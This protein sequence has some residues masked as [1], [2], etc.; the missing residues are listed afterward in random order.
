MLDIE[1]FKA[2]YNCQICR[3]VKDPCVSGFDCSGDFFVLGAVRVDEKLASCICL[4]PLLGEFFTT[5]VIEDGNDEPLSSILSIVPQPNNS[6]DMF[7]KWFGAVV[8]V[9]ANPQLRY[10]PELSGRRMVVFSVSC[11]DGF[12]H[13]GLHD[14][15]GTGGYVKVK[16][17]EAAIMDACFEIIGCVA[18]DP[19]NSAEQ[20]LEK[21]R[22]VATQINGWNRVTSLRGPEVMLM[23]DAFCGRR[24]TLAEVSERELYTFPEKAN[25]QFHFLQEEQE[26]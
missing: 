26:Q 19:E 14:G 24:F 17:R 9:S 20:D 18:M 2:N 25:R 1:D 12:L 6:L 21:L 15:D 4:F 23:P 13:L 16:M 3:F 8:E 7:K 5:I 11:D 10:F 22:W